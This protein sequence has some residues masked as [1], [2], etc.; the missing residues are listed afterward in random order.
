MILFFVLNCAE[1]AINYLTITDLGKQQ[2]L[3]FQVFPEKVIIRYS[4]IPEKVAIA[5]ENSPFRKKL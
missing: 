1:P 4:K 5:A 3:T 2:T